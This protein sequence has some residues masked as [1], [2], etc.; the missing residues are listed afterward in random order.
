M[1]MFFRRLDHALIA[2]MLSM[3]LLSVSAFHAASRTTTTITT[4]STRVV[5]PKSPNSFPRIIQHDGVGRTMKLFSQ[6]S[7]SSND[8]GTQNNIKNSRRSPTTDNNSRQMVDALLGATMSRAMSTLSQKSGDGNFSVPERDD[9]S[10]SEPAKTSDHTADTT[11]VIDAV[12]SRASDKITPTRNDDGDDSTET[13]SHEGNTRKHEDTRDYLSNP[14]VTPTALAHNLWSEVIRP[15]QDIAIDATSGNGKD[16]LILSSMLFPP[17]EEFTVPLDGESSL[18]QPKLISIDIQQRACENTLELLSEHLDAS[19][20]EKCVDVMHASHA[21]MP[22]LPADSVGLICYNLG[23]LPGADKEAFQTQ[24]VTTIYSLADSSLLL[25]KDGLLSVMSY[26]GNGW[27]EHCA[28]SYFM[29]GLA[30]FSTRRKSGWTGFVDSIPCDS[31]L[32][33]RHTSMY[34]DGH[35][36]ATAIP[37]SS[38]IRESVR[39]ALERVKKDGPLKQTT[40]RVFDHRPLGRPLSPILFSAMRLK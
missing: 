39:I 40:W 7:S 8:E 24:M 18:I 4:T 33:A 23:Y 30:M 32:E 20:M 10:V 35:N 31:E 3:L 17:G 12:I 2:A 14:A 38:S 21:P 27:I 13:P 37:G 34:G 6:I 15:Y 22:S 28:V 36:V 26:P 16:S 1:M 5:I 11:N 25:R 9:N 19:I 29:E